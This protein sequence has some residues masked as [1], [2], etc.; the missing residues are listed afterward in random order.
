MTDLGRGSKQN[1]VIDIA[2]L[3]YYRHQ[4]NLFSNMCLNRQYLALNNLSPQL[5]IGLILR[6][7]SD[8]QVPYELR[9][10]FCRLMLHLHVDRDPQEPVTPVKYA[11][12]WSEIPSVMSIYDYD[13]KKTPDTS[14]DYVRARFN[15]T[16]TFVEN[17]LCN[18]VNKMWLF[19]DQDQNKLT[20]EVVKLARDLIYFGFYSFSDLLR[21][22]RTLLSILDC[23]SEGDLNTESQHGDVDS[24]G[25]V[26]RSIG[27]M[28]G[29]M[30]SLALG[31]MKTP[32]IQRS[33]SVSQ[34]MKEYPLVMDTKL[35][36]IEIL[37]F[38]LDVRLDYRISCL[39]SIF[40]REFD[41]SESI[42]NETIAM[43][44]KNFDL[45][46]IGS[47]AEGIFDYQKTSAILDLDG[48]GGRTFLRVLLHLIMHDYPP[49]VS[50]ALHLLFRHFSQRQ[51]V[52]QA[53]RQ[54][55]LL[56]SDQDVESYK[57]IKTDLDV[58]RQCVE[59]SELWVYKSRNPTDDEPAMPARPDD[60]VEGEG[61]QMYPEQAQEYTKIQDILTRMNKLCIQSVPG[62]IFKPRKHEQRLLRNVG[63]HTI[64]LDLLQVPY[65]EKDDVRMNKL[66]QLAHQFLQ[67][68]CL[69]NQHNQVLLHAQ[70]DLFLN[71]GNLYAETVCAIFR[72]N[73]SLCN[74]VNEK[75][76]QHFVHC[77]EI[78][79][80]HVE[81]L[82][83]LQIIVKAENQFIRK[84]QD[85]VMQ[86]LVNAGEDV[87]VFYN[88]K[89]SYN[90]FM[91]MMRN[92]KKGASDNAMA[93]H[94]ELVKLL[95]CCTMGKNVFTEIKCNSLLALDDIV[96]IVCH[97]DCIPPV[98][99][100]YIDFLNHCYIDTE[101]EMKE[102]YSS[103]HMWNIFEKSF[104][105]DLE[106]V[107]QNAPE[108]NETEN[109]V[110]TEL[111]TI[112]ITFFSSPFS[113]QST[114]VQQRQIIF[115][116]LLQKVYKLSRLSCLT[117]PQKFSVESCI[118]TLID[119][120]K[121]RMIAIPSDLEGAVA[122]M[123]SK[124]ALLSRQTSKWLLASKQTKLDRQQSQPKLDRSIIEGLQDIVSL[125]E[126]QL[127]PLVEAELSLLVDILYRS[128]LL[129][130]IGSESRKRCESGGFIRRLIKHAERLLEEKE[131]KLCVE[132]LRTLREMMALDMEYG[133]KGDKLRHNLLE[134]Y[135][136][137]AHVKKPSLDLK[138]LPGT[139]IKPPNV[140]TKLE[141]S[142]QVVTIVTHGP[143]AKFLSRAGRTLYEVQNLLDKE[144][145]GDLVVELVIKSIHSPLIFVEAVELGIAL[146][147]GGNNVIQRGMFN[148]FLALDPSQ[149]FF[150]VFYDKMKDS[151]VEI[152]STVTV[153]TTDIAAKANENREYQRDVDRISRRA[154]PLKSNGIVITDE[155]RDELNN[156]GIATARA[157]A[158]ARNFSGG[159]D[160]NPL[161]PGSGNALEDILAEKLEK[162]KDKDQREKLSPKVL[163][164]QP[165][166][167]FLQLL[168]ENHNPDLQNLLRNQNNKTNYNLVSET[169]LFLDCICGSTTG[170]FLKIS[171]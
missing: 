165:I 112:L 163:V 31:P 149:A 98:K 47:Q 11:R 75:V 60:A 162:H 115:V 147:E 150:R 2:I 43:R 1:V 9:A 103:N 21:L 24:E 161:N 65:D 25:G 116:E 124:T 109:Y 71:P 130:P 73:L 119:V 38:I 155:F 76:I 52:L 107:I 22:T 54:V 113:D 108:N 51:E 63:V 36:I 57:Q 92:Y 93:Y 87:L 40:K 101:V 8:D 85:M 128:E 67:N 142:N 20:F 68:F 15:T 120:A 32:P 114:A 66:M 30:T 157:F 105:G 77:I 164:M 3:D 151:Q 42:S 137:E 123:F 96:S 53:F 121:N 59:K 166:L 131:E 143:G 106:H 46:S 138:V 153:N 90:N 28:G 102:I 86:E 94:I 169:L 125:L 17:Y 117:A 5:E 126:D 171:F 110:F 97:P 39:L 82:K 45:E 100:A 23:V 64:V 99:Q 156:A 122:H 6:C 134:R 133:E 118:K 80:R 167:R 74:E 14:K 135:F 4:L 84:T 111:L 144:G 55:Q 152:K 158:A 49:L 79:G 27:D 83:F 145:A 26:L 48:Q 41:E 58:L 154:V 168:C 62:G 129:F 148:K 70:L 61:P 132:V 170:E 140:L 127:K 91:E 34:I 146:L 33:K 10:S 50:G 141:Y 13:I 69:G 104:L 139:T 12:L 19:S 16:I 18:V 81:Y 37:Q 56:V 72:D 95:G 7:M 160:F 29:I 35:K 88:D 89:A 136:G 44:Q 78:H 159:E